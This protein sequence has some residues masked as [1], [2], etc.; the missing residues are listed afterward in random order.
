[1]TV[2]ARV[3]LAY[4]NFVEPQYSANL[5]ATVSTVTPA[6][7]N[8]T[9]QTA[10]PLTN[11]A[12][13]KLYQPA[14]STL[15]TNAS[16]KFDVDFGETRPI[17][18]VALIRHNLSP[19][20]GTAKVKISL[21]TVSNFASTV[22]PSPAFENVYQPFYNP[23]SF[24]TGWTP[25]DWT[26]SPTQADLQHYRSL[27]YTKVFDTLYLA[28]YMRIEV[29]DTTNTLGYVQLGGVFAGPGFQPNVNFAPGPQ[30]GWRDASTVSAGG[31]GVHFYTVRPRCREAM[32]VL[33]KLGTDQGMQWPFEMEGR[34]GISQK[35]MFVLDPTSS[36][37][38]HRWSFLANLDEVSP[39]EFPYVNPVITKKAIKLVEVL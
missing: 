1:M 26:A 21:S 22:N 12:L 31:S 33:D 34:L 28:R 24:P 9:W 29:D 2:L 20:V 4:P 5:T 32:F 39:L 35:L 10:L 7:S 11:L 16:T 30:I 6:F 15:A 14:R 13:G 23:T 25:S 8:G 37:H 36:Y 38:M 18:V 3:V 19:T 17:S 27:A